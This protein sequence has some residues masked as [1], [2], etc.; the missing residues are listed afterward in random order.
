M[1]QTFLERVTA[2]AGVPAS[3]D[4][5][6][7]WLTD[8]ARKIVDLLPFQ[9]LDK[10]KANVIIAPTGTDLTNHRFVSATREGYV[11]RVFPYAEVGR[12]L[13]PQSFAYPGTKDPIVLFNDGKVYGY[14]TDPALFT[15]QCIPYPTVLHSDEMVAILPKKYEELITL[16]AACSTQ[17]ARLETENAALTAQSTKL[18]TQQTLLTA[19]LASLP[20]FSGV[21]AQLALMLGYITDEEDF[22]KSRAMGEEIQINLS[23]YLNT[24]QGARTKAETIQAGIA[25]ITTDIAIIRARIE[26]VSGQLQVLRGQ[27]VN[28]YQ[29]FFGKGQNDAAR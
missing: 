11:A 13:D 29:I 23:Q 28:L 14:P 17:F 20:T 7:T 8:E 4:T 12:A 10:F 26:L 19:L 18:A 15:A 27:Y 24:L 9:E 1:A 21:D 5:L 2:L 25:I 22:E 3:N 16:G 6:D